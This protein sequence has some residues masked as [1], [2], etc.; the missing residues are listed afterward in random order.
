MRIGIDMRPLQEEYLTGIGRYELSVLKTISSLD[1]SAHG[2][3]RIVLLTFGASPLNAE[4]RSLIAQPLFKHT[5]LKGSNKLRNLH[6]AFGGTIKGDA[7]G[8]DVWWL[9]H[10]GFFRSRTV[11]YVV[12]IHDASFF[13]APFFYSPR[14]RLWHAALHARRLL[15]EAASIIA[16]S[17][18]TKRE[19]IRCIPEVESRVFVCTPAMPISVEPIRH[20]ATTNNLPRPYI[21]FLGT[22]E[23]RK[24]V[25][26]VLKAYRYLTR[27]LRSYDLVIAGAPGWSSGAVHKHIQ[28]EQGVH[29]RSYVS[30]EEK[31]L[32]LHNASAFIWPSFYEGFGFP[33][34]EALAHGVP[35]VASHRTSLPEILRERAS[36]GN[37]HLPLEFARL[38]QR[39]LTT[40]VKKQTEK[41][42][43]DN[44]WKR[45]TEEILLRT[46]LAYEN[47]H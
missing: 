31:M 46:R 8:I 6:I 13:V 9:P 22:I 44:P 37:P 3:E 5:H 27:S 28:S 29:W 19:L 24:N 47:R 7:K 33:P 36:Y 12:T 21:L 17:D 39:A 42:S 30:E 26:A 15:R 34:L 32:L 4:A 2:I 43:P 11:P 25:L 38:L 1:L 41:H 35:V 23:P 10:L 20:T 14:M 16:I 45:H 40:D 18:S